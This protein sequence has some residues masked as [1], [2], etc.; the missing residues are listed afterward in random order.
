M[1][2]EPESPDCRR[3][4]EILAST[5]DRSFSQNGELQRS[6]WDTARP[7]PG[8]DVQDYINRHRRGPVV[9]PGS[10]RPPR[11]RGPTP[12]TPPATA[13]HDSRRRRRRRAWLR[14]Q[15]HVRQGSPGPA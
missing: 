7:L 8:V 4:A 3:V 12:T 2:M 5:P 11:A 6:V 14:A 15:G 1:V 9:S 13:Q 10:E